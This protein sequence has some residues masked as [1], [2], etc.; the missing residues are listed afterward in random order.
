[1]V[2]RPSHLLYMLL[3]CACDGLDAY[4][5]SGGGAPSMVVVMS[6]QMAFNSEEGLQLGFAGYQKG[7]PTV[8]PRGT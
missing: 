7:R 5:A 6:G 4:L 1:M 8:L 2:V 3:P